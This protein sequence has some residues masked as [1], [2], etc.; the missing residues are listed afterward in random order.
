MIVWR[1]KHIDISN[2]TSEDSVRKFN[3]RLRS[4]ENDKDHRSE[5]MGDIEI[6]WHQR[7]AIRSKY[8][9]DEITILKSEKQ[10][11]AALQEQLLNVCTEYEAVKANIRS[12][13]LWL[14]VTCAGWN[15]TET[16]LY[17]SYSL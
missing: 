13:E 17:I 12:L 10:R 1:L 7:D 4:L 15:E 5:M 14:G 11:L 6:L 8:S 9:E 16:G 2:L 3:R